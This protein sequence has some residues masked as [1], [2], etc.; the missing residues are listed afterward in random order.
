LESIKNITITDMIT[1]I[2]ASKDNNSF[3]NVAEIKLVELVG[4]DTTSYIQARENFLKAGEEKEEQK[5]IE[6]EQE[7]SYSLSKNK[8]R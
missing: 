4:I 3:V 1:N 6:R 2:D 5:R 7:K 8:M